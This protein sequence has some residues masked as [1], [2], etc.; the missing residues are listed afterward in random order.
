MSDE[1]ALTKLA[2]QVAH[3]A[4]EGSASGKGA[5]IKPIRDA[6]KAERE[7]RRAAEARAHYLHERLCQY[8]DADHTQLDGHDLADPG[9]PWRH[10]GDCERTTPHCLHHECCV[11]ADPSLSLAALPPETPERKALTDD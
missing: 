2:I 4:V 5:Y 6:L 8:E 3:D 7:L 10:C 9:V 11:C 1:K